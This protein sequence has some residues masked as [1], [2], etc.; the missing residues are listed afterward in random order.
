M[1]SGHCGLRIRVS[2]FAIRAPSYSHLNYHACYWPQEV[3]FSRGFEPLQTL[4]A[5]DR[6]VVAVVVSDVAVSHDSLNPKPRTLNPI[7]PKP[8]MEF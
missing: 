7:N 5:T 4:I 3:L 1:G 8:C 6:G 2:D